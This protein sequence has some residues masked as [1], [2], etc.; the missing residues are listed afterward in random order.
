[1]GMIKKSQVANAL[2]ELGHGW[3]L[4]TME[5]VSN[6]DCVPANTIE[7]HNYW[8]NGYGKDWCVFSY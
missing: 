1:M 7:S 8:C 4:R 2:H 5:N 6:T 3:D